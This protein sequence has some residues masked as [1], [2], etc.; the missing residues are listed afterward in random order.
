MHSKLRQHVDKVSGWRAIR[1]DYD[2]V[3]SLIS[4]KL[5]KV[6]QRLI[7]TTARCQAKLLP[8]RLKLHA[9]FQSEH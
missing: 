2:D 6:K 7:E 8:V 3:R 5:I 1:F 4:Q 9:I